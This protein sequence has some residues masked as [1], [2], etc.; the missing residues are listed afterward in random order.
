MKIIL[1]SRSKA[2]QDIIKQ[3]IP[4]IECIEPQV[5]EL[6]YD[7]NLKKYIVNNAKLKSVNIAKQ[8]PD[9]LVLAYDTVVFCDGKILGK[10]RDLNMAKEMLIFQRGKIE[11]VCTGMYFICVEKNIEIKDISVTQVYF[12]Y[13][14]D[15]I[16][17]EILQ[18]ANIL[19]CAGAYNYKLNGDL[20]VDVFVG[21][22][23]NL[24]GVPLRKTLFYLNQLG[25]TDA[26]ALLKC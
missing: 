10:P 20:Y 25:Y 17:D 6:T 4:D 26:I 1:A 3:Y 14:N 24:I 8:K 22:K 11:Y 16:I 7:N 9:C 12:K 19:H 2:R 5:Q 13:I 23:E 18:D 15:K 21:E